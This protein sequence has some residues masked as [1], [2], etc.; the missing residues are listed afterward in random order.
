MADQLPELM[1]AVEA[2][3]VVPIERHGRVVAEIRPVRRRLGCMRGTVTILGD[4][5]APVDEAWDAE[6]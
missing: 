1:R 5:V 4:V 6:R 3:N 2:G